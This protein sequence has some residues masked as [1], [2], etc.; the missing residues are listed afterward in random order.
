MYALSANNGAAFAALG[1]NAAAFSKLSEALPTSAAGRRRSGL[2]AQN[3]S[4]FLGLAGN[5][6]RTAE[7]DASS[8]FARRCG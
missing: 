3:Q 7:R 2:I 6:G 1:A 4:A 8:Q 5:N